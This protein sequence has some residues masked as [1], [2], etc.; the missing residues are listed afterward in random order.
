MIMR[1]HLDGPV[2]AVRDLERDRRTARID[3]DLAGCRDDLSGN[4]NIASA[5][6]VMDGDQLGAVREGGFDLHLGDHLGDALHHLIA[7]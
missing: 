1:A 5:D 2:A 6:R 4:H 7:G 3:L